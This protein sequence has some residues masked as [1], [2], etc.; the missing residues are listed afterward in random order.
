MMKID[1]NILI[2]QDRSCEMNHCS[3]CKRMPELSPVSETSVSLVVFLKK[4]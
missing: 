4:K 1:K 3:D 2:L